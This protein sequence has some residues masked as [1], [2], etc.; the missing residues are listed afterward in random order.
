MTEMI[1]RACAAQACMTAFAGQPLVWKTRRHCGRL[2]AHSL[3]RMGRNAKLL[4]ACRATSPRG[5]LAYL[6]RNAFGSLVD[7]M[8]ATGLERIAPAMARPGDIVALPSEPGD[9]FGCSLAV[10]LDG[11]RV[12]FADQ[13]SGRF[14]ITT[15]RAFVAAWRV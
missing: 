6:K 14:D 4:N 2:A 7:L 1:Q 11:G 12:L 9:G 13:P 3:M 5:A 10:A 15:P 8:D